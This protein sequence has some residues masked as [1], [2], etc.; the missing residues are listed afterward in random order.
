MASAIRANE[1]CSAS[2][3]SRFA[4]AWAMRASRCTAAACGIAMFLM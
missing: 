2:V 3:A 4:S 1:A